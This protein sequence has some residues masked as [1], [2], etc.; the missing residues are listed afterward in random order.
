MRGRRLA[1]QVNRHRAVLAQRGL[2]EV[3]RYG[4]HRG[5]TGGG[6]QD[7][8]H[9]DLGVRT[10]LRVNRGPQDQARALAGA[11]DGLGQGLAQ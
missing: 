7:V 1:S 5:T 11:R 3:G 6:R 2:R 10:L 8:D 9:R 4:L